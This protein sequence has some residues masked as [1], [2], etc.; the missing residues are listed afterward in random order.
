MPS[1]YTTQFSADSVSAKPTSFPSNT[2]IV[3]LP[4]KSFPGIAQ[5]PAGFGS[6]FTDT[7][8]CHTILR[9]HHV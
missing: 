9:R 1:W 4:A 5:N 7:L 3:K 2:A 8:H 6:F